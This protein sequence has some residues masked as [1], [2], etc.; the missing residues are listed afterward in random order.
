MG[1]H[2]HLTESNV[3]KS[4]SFLGQV[5]IAHTRWAMHYPPGPPAFHNCH[6]IRSDPTNEFTIIHNS[7]VTNSGEVRLILQK[8]GYKFESETDSQAMAVLTKFIY[9][10]QGPSGLGLDWDQTDLDGPW[11]FRSRS[12]SQNFCLGPDCPVS[13]LAKMAWDRTRPNFPNTVH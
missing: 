11:W 12:R 4:K 2:K 7:I 9:D 10:S 6:P 3:N 13:G 1:L 8:C 5:S